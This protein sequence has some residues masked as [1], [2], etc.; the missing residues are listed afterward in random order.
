MVQSSLLRPHETCGGGYW[1]YANRSDAPPTTSEANYN[2][3]ALTEVGSYTNVL[4]AYGTYDQMGNVEEYT[5]TETAF[6]TARRYIR[7]G[8]FTS[9]ATQLSANYPDNDSL[10]VST[11]FYGFRLAGLPE[12]VTASLPVPIPFVSVPV[13]LPTSVRDVNGDG[14]SDLAYVGASAPATTTLNVISATGT[15]LTLTDTTSSA[16]VANFRVAP[17]G[18]LN[19]DG[20]DDVAVIRQTTAGI[21]AEVKVYPGSAT[22]SSLSTSGLKIIRDGATAV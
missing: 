21:D 18:D 8:R 20:Y 14:R 5:D 6:D 12:S 17:L 9:N 10:T 3:N 4:S 22:S 1:D 15:L 19:R 2:G 11:S 13:S 16:S 7:G